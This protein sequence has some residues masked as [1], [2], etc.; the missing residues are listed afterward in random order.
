MAHIIKYME[1][2]QIAQVLYFV[3][4]PVVVTLNPFNS[5]YLQTGTLANNEDPDD[6]ISS[7][8]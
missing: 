7:E 5:G 3:Y 2:V 8:L 6:P 4:F 1:P